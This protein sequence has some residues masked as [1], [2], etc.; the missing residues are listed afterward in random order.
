MEEA[1]GLSPASSPRRGA[2]PA[3]EPESR[4]KLHHRNL[5]KAG[6]FFRGA[7]HRSAARQLKPKTLGSS[8]AGARQL[9]LRPRQLAEDLP[10]TYRQAAEHNLISD[11]F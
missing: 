7:Q 3:L 6:E 8:A 1:L 4:P 11:F 5:S 9:A 10:S 2:A